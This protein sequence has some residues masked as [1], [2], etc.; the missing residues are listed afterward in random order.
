MIYRISSRFLLV[1]LIA[2]GI[3]SRPAGAATITQPSSGKIEFRLHGD[4]TYSGGAQETWARSETTGPYTETA[5]LRADNGDLGVLAQSVA[6]VGSAGNFTPSARVLTSVRWNDSVMLSWNSPL[7]PPELPSSSLLFRFDLAGVVSAS[8][9]GRRSIVNTAQ[10]NVGFEMFNGNYYTN[11]Y[12]GTAFAGGLSGPAFD[13]IEFHQIVTVPVRQT[14]GVP[15]SYRYELLANTIAQRGAATA[16]F[17]NTL[18]LQAVTFTDGLT[19]ESHGFD[20][21]FGSGMSSPNLQVATVPEPASVALFSIG[22][23]GMARMLRRRRRF[24]SMR[25]NGL[26]TDHPIQK[27]GPHGSSNVCH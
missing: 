8:S 3:P 10:S 15:T 22:A 17:A 6:N 5:L 14:L 12:T 13:E 24:V 1:T 18:D 16:D 26:T 27:R 9:P 11:V 25:V 4:A 2:I 7:P 21:I 19:P 20:L 23:L